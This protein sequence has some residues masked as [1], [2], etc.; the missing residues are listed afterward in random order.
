[1][2]CDYFVRLLLIHKTKSDITSKTDLKNLVASADIRL[3]AQAISLAVRLVAC[4]LPWL[5]FGRGELYDIC[6]VI[7]VDGAT[8]IR[9]E[10][11]RLIHTG[12]QRRYAV[13]FV[14][15]ILKK[16]ENAVRSLRK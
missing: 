4:E 12:R 1:M 3:S 5:F 15:E 6:A 16:I 13:L 11:I 10:H 9:V 8:K 14:Q 7:Y 2:G